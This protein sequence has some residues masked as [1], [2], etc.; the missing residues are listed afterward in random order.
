MEE[1]VND[2]NVNDTLTQ[3]K[4]KNA[5]SISNNCETKTNNEQYIYDTPR[6]VKQYS[7]SINEPIYDEIPK[8]YIGKLLDVDEKKVFYKQSAS[9]GLNE[10][11]DLFDVES[12]DRQPLL[13]SVTKERPKP[14][15]N[16]RHP[17]INLIGVKKEKNEEDPFY[18]NIG[19]IHRVDQ[20]SD[21]DDEQ[22]SQTVST[23]IEFINFY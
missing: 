3:Q 15:Q 7:H 23:K 8:D 21:S 4:Q 5:V 14:P 19:F 10:N 18:V 13:Y 12:I 6:S 22:L 2:E 16:R 1:K 9:R 20:A 11:Y 17:S